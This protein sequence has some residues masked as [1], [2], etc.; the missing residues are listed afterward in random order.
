MA[1]STTLAE[2]RGYISAVER[3]RV[4]NL[5]SR[6]GLAIDDP[7]LTPDL[8]ASATQSILGT[9]DGLLRAAVPRPIGTC[10]FVNDADLDELVATLAAHRELCAA[11][12]REGAGVEMSSEVSAASPAGV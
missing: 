6:L 3:D 2:R 9:R 1:Y 12:P 4:L 7:H 8:L 5:M 10:E 11:L